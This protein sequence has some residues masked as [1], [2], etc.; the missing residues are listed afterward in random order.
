M[1]K[2]EFEG[3]IYKNSVFR[4]KAYADDVF[5]SQ[6][7]GGKVL[8][9]RFRGMPEVGSPAPESARADASCNPP[10]GAAANCR[11]RRWRCREAEPN[12]EST[13][14]PPYAVRTPEA[15]LPE[16]T[17]RPAG[18]CAPP[19]PCREQRLDA[20]RSPEKRQRAA[21]SGGSAERNVRNRREKLAVCE[22]KRIFVC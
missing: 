22:I 21:V 2:S 9:R 6:R 15:C 17:L 5:I 13:G 3:S 19:T 16:Q 8:R 4:R 12:F 18:R 11:H 7:P 20:L 1:K 14:E 10:R